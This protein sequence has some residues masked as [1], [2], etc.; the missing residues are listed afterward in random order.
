MHFY[1]FHEIVLDD[2]IFFTNFLQIMGGVKVGIDINNNLKLDYDSFQHYSIEDMF[3]NDPYELF[4]IFYC[5][6]H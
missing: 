3:A 1:I 2:S 4:S 6:Y 5:I